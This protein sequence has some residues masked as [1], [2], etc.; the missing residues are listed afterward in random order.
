MLSNTRGLAKSMALE[1]VGGGIQL[2]VVDSGDG[3]HA[4]VDRSSWGLGLVSM[5]E[6]ARVVDGKLDVESTPGK[7]T[8]VRCWVPLPTEDDIE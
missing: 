5:E 4:D 6:R 8:S 3:F 2:S 1:R 7:G